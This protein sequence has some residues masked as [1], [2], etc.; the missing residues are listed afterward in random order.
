MTHCQRGWL[1]QEL[2]NVTSVGN[3]AKSNAM[4][5]QECVGVSIQ[6]LA[7]PWLEV[8]HKGPQ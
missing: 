3:I 5:V 4:E 2:H 7:K 6:I 8:T 1:D